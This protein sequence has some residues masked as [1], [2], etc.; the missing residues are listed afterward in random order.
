VVY[1][2]TLSPIQLGGVGLMAVALWTIRRP[3]SMGA[4]TPGPTT[5]SR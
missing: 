1:G 3:R 2:R 4:G 5:A